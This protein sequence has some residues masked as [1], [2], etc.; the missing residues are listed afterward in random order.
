[1]W[2]KV[3]VCVLSEAQGNERTKNRKQVFDK[4]D[5]SI[6]RLRPSSKSCLVL[7]TQVEIDLLFMR[8][9]E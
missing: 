8:L 4:R 2:I 6:V 7:L 3:G 5:I 1:M 9:D